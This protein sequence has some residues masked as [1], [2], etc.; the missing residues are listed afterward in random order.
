MIAICCSFEDRNWVQRQQ[1]A[2]QSPKAALTEVWRSFECF[3]NPVTFLSQKTI[4]FRGFAQ[5]FMHW[6]VWPRAVVPL[7]AAQK[8]QVPKGSSSLL[9]DCPFAGEKSWVNDAHLRQLQMLWHPAGWLLSVVWIPEHRGLADS[10]WQTRK[11]LAEHWSA[12]AEVTEIKHQTWKCSQ[13]WCSGTWTIRNIY[14]SLETKEVLH[15]AMQT[16]Y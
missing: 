14:R 12:L 11:S 3:C 16:Q 15:C 7:R 6:T 8:F 9:S 4:N 2:I 1:N 5:T 10:S 13:H